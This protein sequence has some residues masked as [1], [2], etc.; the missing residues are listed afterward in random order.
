MLENGELPTAKVYLLFEHKGAPE[1]LVGMQVFR[2]MGLQWKDLYDQGKIV[3]GKLPPIIPIVIYQGQENWRIRTSFQDLVE[4]PSESFSAYIPHFSFAFFNVKGIDEKKVQ[5]NVI[6]KF[7]V[8]MIKQQ[9]TPD[10]KDFPIKLAQGLLESLERK[11]ALEYM[12]IFFK[13]LT[14]ATD[15]VQEEDYRKALDLVPEGGENIM[16]TLADQWIQQG[17]EEVLLEKPYWE[18]QA[19]LENTKE[20]LIDVATEQYGPL[21]S[22]LH[23]KI[24]SIQSLENLRAL[25]RRVIKTQSL[26]EFSE[27]VNQA[28]Q[29]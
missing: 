10:I 18:Q 26:E 13:Y 24:K 9:N 17:K 16:N 21:P 28:A 19:K 22:M 6:L 3:G 4:L 8:E 25:H 23:E 2:Y 5:E 11:T 14:K 12:E 20:T 7:Y 15:T 27:L 1:S 29:Q